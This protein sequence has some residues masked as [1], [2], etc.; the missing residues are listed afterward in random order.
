MAISGKKSTITISTQETSPVD[1]LS[2][3]CIK[4][5]G[6]MSITADTIDVT[7]HGDANIRKKIKGLV[8]FG[9]FDVTIEYK[10]K[11]VSKDLYDALISD[12]SYDVDIQIVKAG[13]TKEH[14][15]FSAIITGTGI[16]VP[17]MMR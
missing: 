6:N 2:G 7:C 12:S 10:D 9:S 14:L 1:I 16:E 11:D 3:V 8:D 15:T 4:S 13:G 5:I 17:M